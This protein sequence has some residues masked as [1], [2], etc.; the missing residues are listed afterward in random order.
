MAFDVHHAVTDKIIAT[1]EAGEAG[2]WTC[3][4]HRTGGGLPRNALTGKAYR[5]I[6]TLSLWVGAQ[7]AGYSD[8][9]WATYKQWAELGTQVKRGERSTLVVFFKEYEA[10]D[11]EDRKR[12][13]ARASYA[14]NASQ[15][16]GAPEAGE[17]HPASEWTIPDVFDGFVQRTGARIT[18]GGD[19]AFYQ[20][21]ED[22]IVL[23]RRERFATSQG[24][25][26]TAAH[27][28]VH[29]SGAKGRLDRDLTGR[30]KTQAYAAEEL[31]AELGS[32]FLLAEMGLEAEPHPTHASYLA[33]WLKLLRS[34]PKAI[35]TAASAASRAAGFLTSLQ[36]EM[37]E[38]A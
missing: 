5:G 3:P 16:E 36:A 33:S 26:S 37:A 8:D 23:P 1:M 10:A 22:R 9:R 25:A 29:W 11:G 6:N 24:Y 4:W 17:P 13:V 38:A 27:E 28:L 15:V 20:P 31:I 18:H 19:A 30:F 21:S 7:A 34:D 2:Q 32:A 35:F 14:F 12:F